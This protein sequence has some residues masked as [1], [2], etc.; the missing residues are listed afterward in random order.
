MLMP[1]QEVADGLSALSVAA[2][3]GER[4]QDLKLLALKLRDGLPLG[5]RRGHRLPV[6]FGQRRLLVEGFQ[7][8]RSTGHAQEDDS[9]DAGRVVRQSECAAAARAQTRCHR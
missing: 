7:M 4:P 8:R 9:L 1:R 6:E 2:E 5:E 3:F